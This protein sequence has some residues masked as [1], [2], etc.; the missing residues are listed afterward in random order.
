MCVCV[1]GG[2]QHDFAVCRSKC[3]G[4]H[5][6]T[7]CTC[8]FCP[9]YDHAF[10]QACTWSY[11]CRSIINLF[12]SHLWKH[13]HTNPSSRTIII[14]FHL[15]ADNQTSNHVSIHLFLK[16]IFSLRIEKLKWKCC[17]MS[18]NSI[19]LD[20]FMKI[21]FSPKCHICIFYLEPTWHAKMTGPREQRQTTVIRH[22]NNHN[23]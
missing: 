5:F 12:Q 4:L 8:H 10:L 20:M 1:C 11:A 16:C 18:S 15:Q 7:A 9:I 22:V 19:L 21:M 14:L 6:Q 2:R 17:K 13:T 23:A 3:Q